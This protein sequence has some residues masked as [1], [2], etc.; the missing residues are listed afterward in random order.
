MT[1]DIKLSNEDKQEIRII[2]RYL[3]EKGAITEEEYRRAVTI[4]NNYK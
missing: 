1:D 2:F 4:L 3:L